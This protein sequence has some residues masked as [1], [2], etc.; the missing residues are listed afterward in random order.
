MKVLVLN[1]SPKRDASDTMHITR[2]FLQ[3]MAKAVPLEAEILSVADLHIHP[4]S[5][6]F[7]C[8]H[9]GGA[10][11][12]R[13]DMSGVLE[14]IQACEVLL[15]SYPLY[16]YGMPGPL[17]TLVDRILPLTA[18]T[19][20]KV[21]DR[22]EHLSRVDLSHQRYVMICGCGFPNSTHNFEAAIQQF[23]LL[24]PEN[25]T[26]LT[27]PESPL[28]NVPQAAPVT[29][30]RLALVEQAGEAY[31]RKGALSDAQVE[32][33]SSPMIPHE[34]YAQIVNSQA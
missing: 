17:K 23:Q 3:G 8:W 29:A 2:A 32:A 15:L 19:M 10:C 11:V 31:A 5:G 1:G 9:N 7:A 13:D 26:I 18:M 16:C 33:I 25:H 14:K 6:C 22:Y 20:R 34:E 12:H 4:C 24:F 30:P 28:F 27:L 21:G